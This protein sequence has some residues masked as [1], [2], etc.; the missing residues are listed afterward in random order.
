MLA[1]RL[2]G[3]TKWY[4]VSIIVSEY[5]LKALTYPERLNIRLIGKV[6]V[7]GKQEPIIIFEV[8]DGDPADI[9]ELKQRT[10]A[11][12]DEGQRSYFK[13]DFAT[14]VECFTNVLAI[15]PDDR[16]AQLYAQRVRECLAHGVPDD[17]QGI[18]TMESK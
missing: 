15:Y 17:W 7:K 12:F 11:D 2:E 6:K 5:T 14:A 13:R 8:Y 10:Q 18:D 3:L 16:P 1:S 9:L 4:G